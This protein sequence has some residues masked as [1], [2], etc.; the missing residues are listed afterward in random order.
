M[1]VT[2]VDILSVRRMTAEL[3][4]DVY[5]DIDIQTIIEKYPMLDEEGQEPY[6]YEGSIPT[7]VENEYWIPTYNLNLAASEIWEHKAALLAGRFDFSADGGNYSRSQAYNQAMNM[8][9]Y[10]RS[11][12]GVSTIKQVKVPEEV[13]QTSDWIAN[14]PESDE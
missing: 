9:R 4:T 10:Y 5:P 14:L 12:G 13:S 1:T 11:R 8:V 3:D 7:R 6:Y 2:A